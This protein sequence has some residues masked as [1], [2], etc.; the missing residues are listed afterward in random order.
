[1]SRRNIYIHT[2]RFTEKQILKVVIFGGGDAPFGRTHRMPLYSET[3]G[4]SSELIRS[5]VNLMVHP[6]TPKKYMD[7]VVYQWYTKILPKNEVGWVL[8]HTK[9]IWVGMEVCAMELR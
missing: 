4:H 6:A 9:I 2:I 1:M 7:D 3:I 5:S 8:N